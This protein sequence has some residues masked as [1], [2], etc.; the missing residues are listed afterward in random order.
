M[1]TEPTT[2]GRRG[3]DLLLLLTFFALLAAGVV[4]AL[5][6]FV[7][8]PAAV[9]ALAVVVAVVGLA[10]FFVAG[11]RQARRSGDGVLRSF[12]RALWG[13]VRLAFDLF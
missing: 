10:V 2:S 7:E 1:S 4:A 11:V 3:L 8:L 9:V 5:S 6:F 13:T 12:G